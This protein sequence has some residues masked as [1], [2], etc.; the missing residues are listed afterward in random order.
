MA[1]QA[2]NTTIS[3]SSDGG[4]TWLLVGE[5]QTLGDVDFGAKDVVTI[6]SLDTEDI[7]KILG[8]LKLGNMDLSYVYN[9]AEAE[10]NGVIKTSFDATVT[11]PIDVRI[12]L[13][14][15]KGTNGTQFSFTAIVPSYKIS[16]FEK[17]GFLKSVVT[18][19]QTTKPTV[20]AAA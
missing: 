17:N 15:S 16:G 10:G 12:E 7:D 5:I 11:T 18:I 20:T 8:T 4:N 6:D 14:D 19:E 2:Q 1:I 3:V 13:P 9:P